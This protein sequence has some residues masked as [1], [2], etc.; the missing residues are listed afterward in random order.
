MS[1]GDFRGLV[2]VPFVSEGLI[3]GIRRFPW[4]RKWCDASCASHKG[5][6]VV[7][8]EIQCLCRGNNLGGDVDVARVRAAVHHDTQASEDPAAIIRRETIF[9]KFSIELGQYKRRQIPVPQA[10][11]EDPEFGIGEF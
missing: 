7:G 9:V 10:G 2:K 1:A 4:Y 5:T 11:L 8:R 6:V 3:D